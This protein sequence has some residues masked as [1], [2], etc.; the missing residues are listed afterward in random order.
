MS[1]T[2]GSPI[3]GYRAFLLDIDGV[4][5]R[6]A[7]VLDEAI[8]AVA[9]LRTHGGVILLT[10]NSSRSRVQV[11]EKLSSLGLPISPQDVLPTSS[12]AA[13][14][15]KREAGSVT[16][17]PLGEDGLAHELETA[18]H[19]R[20]ER[21]IDAEWVVAGIDRHL[22]YDKLAAALLALDSGARLL[23]TN[24]DSTFPVAD[25][26]RPGAGAIIG[27]LQGMGF[28]PEAVVGKPS[29]IA[30]EAALNALGEGSQPALMIGDRLETDIL[31]GRNAGMD[32]A[33]VLTGVTDRDIL[34]RS[35]IRPTWIATS[36]ASLVTGEAESVA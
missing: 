9:T 14:F 10:N 28:E 33:L 25:G 4:L 16:F 23:A 31:G 34:E 20:A 35:S 22:T 17:W 7:E 29:P 30:Y 26:I 21:P 15:L 3:L 11:A 8:E 24:L 12:I 36:L 6:G 13:D 5:I 19:R 32:T 2:S 18:G 1:I 27:A